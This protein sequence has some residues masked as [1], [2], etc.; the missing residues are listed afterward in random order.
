M[1][2]HGKTKRRRAAEDEVAQ[3]GEILRDDSGQMYVRS[4][5]GSNKIRKLK[6]QSLDD[7]IEQKVEEKLGDLL[8]MA[9][10]ELIEEAEVEL[11]ATAT[12]VGGGGAIESDFEDE[13][14][15]D[16]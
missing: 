2:T 4:R 7:L 13:D 16:M 3:E 8:E 9:N 5:D 1:R 14:E 10:E 12:T 11:A 6:K 15:D